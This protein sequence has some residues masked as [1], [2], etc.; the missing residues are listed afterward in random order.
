MS[1]FRK[2]HTHIQTPNNKKKISVLESSRNDTVETTERE[3]RIESSWSGR[4]TER[5]LS[6]IRMFSLRGG[7]TSFETGY[8]TVRTGVTSPLAKNNTPFYRVTMFYAFL[9][10]FRFRRD[11]SRRFFFCI[12][13]EIGRKCVSA[14]FGRK[15][16]AG[17]RGFGG[18]KKSAA[19]GGTA[20]LKNYFGSDFMKYERVGKSQ[21][22]FT[23]WESFHA[24]CFK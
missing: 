7:E 1:A 11:F 15:C 17:S 10:S 14:G 8:R 3:W 24:N 21:W 18:K 9:V 12:V 6:W 5:C 20:A 22:K 19:L 2:N 4:K 23:S 13:L 16:A